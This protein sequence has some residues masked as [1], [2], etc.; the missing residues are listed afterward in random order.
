MAAKRG[1]PQKPYQASW[2]D[3]V[4]GLAR[5]SDGR[6][7]IVAT[8]FRFSDADERR[9]VARAVRIINPHRETLVHAKVG[10]VLGEE[11]ESYDEFVDSRRLFD[12]LDQTAETDL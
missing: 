10:D 1:R 2:G 7:R 6:W 5:D 12:L 3:I 8:G 11:F 4:P 9:A